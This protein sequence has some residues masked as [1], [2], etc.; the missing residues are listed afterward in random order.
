MITSIISV[1]LKSVIEVNNTLIH[2]YRIQ[3]LIEITI[4]KI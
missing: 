4:N 2:F 3:K 1:A